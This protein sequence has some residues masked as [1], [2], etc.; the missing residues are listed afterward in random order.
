MTNYA[1]ERWQW[2]P[3]NSSA[4]TMQSKNENQGVENVQSAGVN[5]LSTFGQAGQIDTVE[6]EVSSHILALDVNIIEQLKKQLPRNL[7]QDE[8]EES[9]LK[10]RLLSEKA[11]EDLQRHV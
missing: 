5:T 4:A 6:D 7:L 10:K 1:N 11:L 3:R 9:K 8:E 2:T